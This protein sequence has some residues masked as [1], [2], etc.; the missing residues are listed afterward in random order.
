[1]II[2]EL[3]EFNRKVLS[4]EKDEEVRLLKMGEFLQSKGFKSPESQQLLI[5]CLDATDQYS[6]F[7]SLA[8]FLAVIFFVILVLSGDSEIVHPVFFTISASVIGV[9]LLAIFLII[10]QMINNE[11]KQISNL[12]RSKVTKSYSNSS[13]N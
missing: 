12:I 2:E 11:R 6:L 7:Y 1:M 3:F 8:M 9:L 13:D 10:K 5:D 4:K